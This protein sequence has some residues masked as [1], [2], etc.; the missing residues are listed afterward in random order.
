MPVWEISS[1]FVG[2]KLGE[3][4]TLVLVPGV[5]FKQNGKEIKEG[6][7]WLENQGAF[8]QIQNK[9]TMRPS[10]NKVVMPCLTSPFESSSMTYPIW[11]RKILQGLVRIYNHYPCKH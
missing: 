5:V 6:L 8:I 4:P 1:V 10:S 11:I 9:F 2:D 3:P 7:Y